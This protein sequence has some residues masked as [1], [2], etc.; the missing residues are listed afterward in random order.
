MVYRAINNNN[1]AI[2]TTTRNRRMK[3]ER[4]KKRTVCTLILRMSVLLLLV[5]ASGYAVITVGRGIGISNKSMI[6]RQLPASSSSSSSTTT[7][8]SSSSSIVVGDIQTQHTQTQTQSLFPDVK[9]KQIENYRKGDGLML[10]IH[11]IHHAGTTF[12][13]LIGRNGI[14]NSI[15]PG[16]A[17]MGDKDNIMY[18]SSI[19]K[20]DKNDNSNNTYF[21]E[22][23]GNGKIP[24]GHNET[25]DNINSIRPYFSMISWEFNGKNINNKPDTHILEDTN[26]DHPRLLSVIIT[27]D[28]ISRLLAGDGTVSR[29]YPGYDSGNL[30]H[31]GWWEYVTDETIPHTNNLFLR[32]VGGEKWIKNKEQQEEKDKK[33]KKEEEEEEENKKNLTLTNNASTTILPSSPPSS[34]SSSELRPLF[35]NQTSYEHAVDVLNRFTIVLDI[36]CLNEGMIELAKLLNLNAT[37]FFADY[38]KR[39]PHRKDDNCISNNNTSRERIGYDD[40]YNYL[41]EKNKWDILLYEYSKNISLVRCDGLK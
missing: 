6:E 38:N 15:S 9:R 36:E 1:T 12:C 5:F 32:I 17:C 10:N 8:S 37:K 7:S 19:T 26:W 27:R 4:I 21:N 3:R 25:N 18:N 11:P 30:N 41:L 20:S 13:K 33:K 2:T 24:W 22:Y 14:N 29:K 39:K 28:P 34:S 31:N 23:G 40:V 16:F 35:L